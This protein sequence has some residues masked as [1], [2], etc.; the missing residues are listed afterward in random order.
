MLTRALQGGVVS[1]ITVGLVGPVLE[2]VLFRGVLLRGFV[3]GYEGYLQSSCLL[4]CSQYHILLSHSFRW[5]V[6]QAASVC[7]LGV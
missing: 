2:E 6:L 3:A 1:F 5:R 7:G 4:P